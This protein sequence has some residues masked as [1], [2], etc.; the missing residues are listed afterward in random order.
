MTSPPRKIL[1]RTNRFARDLKPLPQ[2]VKVE[3]YEIAQMLSESIFHLDLDVR[4]LTG[5]KG[6]FRVVVA[7]DYRLIF[8]FDE[9]NLY[10]RR[11]GHRREIYR[12]LE[13]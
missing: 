7:K 13:L 6:Y 1:L 3:A 10:L 12:R 9:K 2:S 4:P 11:I 8:S 5:F